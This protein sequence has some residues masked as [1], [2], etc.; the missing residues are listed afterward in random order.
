MSIEALDELKAIRDNAPYG[1]VGIS[2]SGFYI[3][4]ECHAWLNDVWFENTEAETCRS[5][6]DINRII[7]L[8]EQSQNLESTYIEVLCHVTD[9]RMSKL[10]LDSSI[11]KCVVDAVAK[12][13]S[14]RLQAVLYEMA[15]NATSNGFH[16]HAEAINEALERLDEEGLLL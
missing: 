2:D 4:D 15:E 1:A 9:S 8:S 14:E 7:E 3:N 6:S 12:E 5:L 10:Y 11:V 13:K 16:D